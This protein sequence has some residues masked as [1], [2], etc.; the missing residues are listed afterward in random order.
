MQR[1]GSQKFY[2]QNNNVLGNV[3]FLLFDC[4]QGVIALI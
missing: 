4:Y 1:R 2:D 3:L